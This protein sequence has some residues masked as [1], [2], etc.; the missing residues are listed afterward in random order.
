VLIRVGHASEPEV[1]PA[2]DRPAGDER[3]FDIDRQSADR[4]SHA[5]G[6]SFA[7]A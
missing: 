4:A 7:L 3:D 6:P 2:P 1:P 5:T